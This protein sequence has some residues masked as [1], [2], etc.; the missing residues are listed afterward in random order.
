[1]NG[2]EKKKKN[3]TNKIMKWKEEWQ[4][5]KICDKDNNMKIKM[6]L[7]IPKKKKKSHTMGR[8]HRKREKKKFFHRTNKKKNLS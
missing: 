4:H 6:M 3:L 8:K 2:N 7:F 1:M 5:K